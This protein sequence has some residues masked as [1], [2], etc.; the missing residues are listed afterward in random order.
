MHVKLVDGDG[1]TGG[2]DCSV[3]IS[4]NSHI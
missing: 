1:G 3:D 2:Q 4:T